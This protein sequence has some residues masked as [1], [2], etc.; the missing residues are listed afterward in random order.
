MAILTGFKAVMNCDLKLGD[1][2]AV[3]GA[4]GGLGHLAGTS[5]FW[6]LPSSTYLEAKLILSLFPRKKSNMAKPAAHE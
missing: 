4:G 6:M 5:Q 2:L 1:W 3:I